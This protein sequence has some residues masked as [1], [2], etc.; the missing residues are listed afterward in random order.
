MAHDF[1]PLWD[2][3]K[4]KMQNPQNLSEA[5]TAARFSVDHRVGSAEHVL[6]VTLSEC[7]LGLRP[8]NFTQRAE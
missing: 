8:Q 4:R 6:E 3:I 7:V 2:C 5:N 1:D